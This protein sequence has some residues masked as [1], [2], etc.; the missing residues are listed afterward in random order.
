VK[1]ISLIFVLMTFLSGCT[2]M[3]T[4]NSSVISPIK[5]IQLSAESAPVNLKGIFEFKVKSADTEQR[6]VFLNS[7][8]DNLDQRNLSIALRPNAVKELIQKYGNNPKEFL[9]D[10]NIRVK[11]EAKRVKTWVLYKNKNTKRYYYQTKIFV[12]SANQLTVL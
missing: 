6:L 2:Q 10:K 1:N 11:G 3:T 4:V 9:L 5:A 7:E 8:I 12:K